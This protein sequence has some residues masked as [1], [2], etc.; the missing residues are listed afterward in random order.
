[1]DQWSCVATAD[2]M[3]EFISG[4]THPKISHEKNLNN[5]IYHIKNKII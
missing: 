2:K 4:L 1:M 5:I 3:D